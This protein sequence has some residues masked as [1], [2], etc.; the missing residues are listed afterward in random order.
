LTWNV[1][2]PAQPK[3]R[4]AERSVSNTLADLVADRLQGTRTTLDRLAAPQLRIPKEPVR[5]SLAVA[6]AK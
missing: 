1:R 5:L 3:H 2:T 6:G 4:A